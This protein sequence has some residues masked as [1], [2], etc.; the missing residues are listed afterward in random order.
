MKEQDF[1]ASQTAALSRNGVEFERR[2]I[3]V[4]I[5]NGSAQ[6]LVSGDGPPAILLNGIGT[7]AAMWAPLM[8]QL[9]GLTLYAV[10][11]PGYGLTS[12]TPALTQDMRTTAIA[13][14]GQILERLELNQPAIIANSLGSNWASWFALDQPQRVAALVHVGCPALILGTSAPLPMRLL[15]KRGLGWLMMR[16]QPPS[17]RQVEKLSRMVNEYPLPQEI[18]DLLLATE[19]LPFFEPTFLAMLNALIRLRGARPEMALSRERL[20]QITTPSLLI[21]ARSDPFGG[22]EVGRE[23]ADAMPDAKLHIVDGGHTPW[24]HNAEKIAP[25]IIDFLGSRSTQSLT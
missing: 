1:L 22:I 5:V 4:P 25:L 12:S 14:L 3:D 24:I 13:F 23:A 10:D 8:G 11:L 16:I 18:A 21:F 17:P 7:P 9:D 6:V 19:R 20:K 15:S 2:F